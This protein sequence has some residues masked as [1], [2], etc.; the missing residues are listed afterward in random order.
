MR[1]VRIC[2]FCLA[3]CGSGCLAAGWTNPA[4]AGADQAK[5]GSQ[6][7]AVKEDVQPGGRGEG[8]Q[9]ECATDECPTTFG[10]IITDTAIPMEKG[11]F[12]LQPTLGLEFYYPQL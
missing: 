3:L 1:Y 12:A 6:P 9:P 2:W 10:P 11:K 7:A 4:I 5:A 8:F